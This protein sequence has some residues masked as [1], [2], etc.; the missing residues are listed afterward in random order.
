MMFACVWV[1]FCLEDI[2][3]LHFAGNTK[4]DCLLVFKLRTLKLPIKS[5][6]ATPHPR[7]TTREM[8]LPIL[9]SSVGTPGK[10]LKQLP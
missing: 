10:K 4:G 5:R 3:A 7:P 2:R 9:S 1:C 8:A 6:R